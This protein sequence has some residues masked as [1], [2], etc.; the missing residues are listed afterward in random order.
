MH[1]PLNVRFIH[2]TLQWMHWCWY[3]E[4]WHAE[5]AWHIFHCISEGWH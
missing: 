5:R 3:D 2:S 1:G 4:H